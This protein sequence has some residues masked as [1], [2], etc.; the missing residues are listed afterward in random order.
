MTAAAAPAVAASSPGA[1]RV[2]APLG[3]WTLLLAIAITLLLSA[4]WTA[5]DWATLS[6]VWLPDNDDM[7]RIV[8]IR[9]WIAGQGFNDL[10]QHR[11]GMPGG[12]SM[13]WSR[14]ADA[15]PALIVVLLTPLAG[16]HAAE[17]AAVIAWPAL[18]FLAYLLL[19]ARI[20]GRLGGAEARIPALILAALAFP[21]ISLFLPGRIDHHGL[22]IVLTIWLLD[23]VV[24]APSFRQGLAGGFATALSLAI[25]LEAAPE[26]LA[27]LAAMGIAW[28]AGGRGDDR[29]ALGFAAALGGVTLALLA[30]ARPEVWPEQ[31]CDGFTPASS[32]ATLVLAGAWGLL[33]LAG[34]RVQGWKPRL[35]VAAGL[36]AATAALA[37]RTSSV[38]LSGPYGALDPFLQ[39]VWMRN[40]NEANSLLQQDTLGTMVAYG[41]LVLPGAALALWH[42][43]RD[44]RWQG[45]AVFLLLCAVASVLQVRVTYIVAGIAVV[46]FA[47]L[48][49]RDGSL[50][51]RLALWTL[52]AGIGWN[53]AAAQ[54]DA[55]FARPV[56]AA[57]AV[58]EKCLSPEGIAVIAAQPR[59]SVMAPLDLD[60]YLLAMTPHRV[61]ASLYH[62]NN[63]GNMAM[64]RFFLSP[65]E[66]ARAQAGAEGIGYVA[67]CADQLHENG[68]APYRPG[69]LAERL[70]SGAPPP[71]WLEPIPTGSPIRLYRVR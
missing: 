48:L 36:G 59:G 22:Q 71:A 3:R 38:C 16:A 42:L 33:G 17:V 11:S 29:R 63:A 56:L 4:A 55:A 54:L 53:L 40:V 70:Q 26:I 37:W 60:S 32:R 57:R 39:R 35:A 64:Y 45:Y 28:F 8:Q 30:F 23:T 66:R 68:L 19:I 15:V 34:G 6:L 21:T 44:R 20:A 43:A 5:K 1:A 65:P 49:A 47:A 10:L 52:G 7:V 41:G 67:L 27:A 18:L 50:V 31:W 24:A 46:P 9:D 12:A 51:R 13:H 69:S 14:I 25:G 58:Q 2:A 62:R 61:V